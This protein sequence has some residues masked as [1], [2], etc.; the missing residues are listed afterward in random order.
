MP[1]LPGD[2][3]APQGAQGENMPMAER[4]AGPEQRGAMAF[5]AVLDAGRARSRR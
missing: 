4:F 3:A 5:G 1:Q 2:H